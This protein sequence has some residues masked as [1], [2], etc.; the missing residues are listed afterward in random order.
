MKKMFALAL[1]LILTLTTVGAL[2]ESCFTESALV[3]G[4]EWDEK[5]NAWVI[6]CLTEDGE[7][8]SFYADEGSWDQGDLLTLILTD[9]EEPAVIDVIWVG[10]DPWAELLL[11]E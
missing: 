9:C 6:D 3:I 10:F 8:W 11:A 7:V 4:K 2:A 1:I 5:E